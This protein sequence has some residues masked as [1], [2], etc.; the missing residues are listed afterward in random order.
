[1]APA[2]ALTA[3]SS[4]LHLIGS[5]VLSHTGMALF[6]LP[7][8]V[9]S[10]TLAAHGV[11][12]RSAGYAF[13]S[14]MML[15]LAVTLG[16]V[17][18]EAKPVRIIQANL[19]ASAIFSLLWLA[20]SRQLASREAEKQALP[21]LLLRSQIGFT[22]LAAL[23]LLAVADVRLLAD[24]WQPSQMAAAMGGAWGWVTVALPALAFARL[25]KWRLERLRIDWLGVGLLAIVSLVGCSV[26]LVAP[27]W[28]VYHALMIGIAASAWTMLALCWQREAIFNR[29]N[30]EGDDT[31]VL[32]ATCLGM[33]QVLVTLRGMEAPGDVWWTAGSFAVL[34]LLFTGLAVVTRHRGYVYL[35]GVF[36][37]LVVTRLAVWIAPQPG[38]FVSLILIN[39]I[40][41]CLAS[42]VW[43][44][45]DLT[46]MRQPGTSRIA[47]FHRIAAR[48]ALAVVAFTAA[49]HW[50]MN[51]G[52][53][54]FNVRLEWYA[55]GA[56][57][58]LLIG[59][60]WDDESDLSW[61]GLHLAGVMLVATA[62]ASAHLFSFP[63]LACTAAALSLYALA[64]VLLWR[65]RDA[66]TRMVERLRI[67]R[68]AGMSERVWSWLA[69][70][71]VLI[72]ALV[73]FCSLATV[74][75]SGSLKVRLLITTAAFA[76]PPAFALLA[77]GER[78]QRLIA[79]SI[80]LCLLDV[81]LWCWAWLQYP[82]QSTSLQL[83]NRL[84]IVML[85][86]EA[87]LI[88]Y[89]LVAVNQLSAESEWR[90]AWR[91]DLW[92][93]A[94]AGLASLAVVL[95]VEVSNYAILGSA[96]ISGP[97]ILAVLV[98]LIGLRLIGLAFA[99][100]PGEDPFGL[101]ERG[102]MRYVYA[103]E[104]FIVLTL[105]HVRVTMPWLFGGRFT[106]YWPLIVLAI[107]FAGV[108]LSEL[109]RRQGKL[110]LAE[111]LER[112]GALLPL[113]PVIGFW[114]V[115]SQVSYSMLLLL[116]GLF[117][118]WLSVIRHSFGFGLLAALA[119]N[120]GLW[121]FLHGEASYA[122]SEH[123]QLWMIP[124]ALSVLLATR[125][126][127][128]DGRDSLSAEQLSSIRYGALITIYVSSTADIFLNGVDDSP[129]LPIVLAVL[130]V[131]GVIAGI[132]LRI[133]SFLFLGTAF[134]LLSMLTMIWSAS[135][136]MHWAWLWWVTGIAL[137]VFI[138]YT[139]AMFE[140]K[141]EEMLR[142][143][144]QLKQWQ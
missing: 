50:L 126:T 141:R 104:G 19:T 69:K 52:V 30:P 96:L 144:G 86:A 63:L 6:L 3:F 54:P 56:L 137:G 60:L 84:V 87:V 29:V 32:W 43:L 40:T 61:R 109:F 51:L 42:L 57:V 73:A 143:V 2:L 131:C 1:A 74:F 16:L 94:V 113:L 71:N 136:N 103:V 24:A 132:M 123:P 114:A 101:D 81:L 76:L 75:G 91:D 67:P 115:G 128:K 37:N 65:R 46:V 38:D 68:R 41:L 106:T 13:A 8:C 122:F 110:I 4:F 59:C 83:I 107:A 48:I 133:R 23:A 28:T 77:R 105:M 34:C 111:P 12:K 100:L 62:F 17:F 134:L 66:L 39:V 36:C 70:S 116:A 112:T 33:A 97:V 18:A 21:S 88:A 80:R 49:I 78:R 102:R 58:A 90:T 31:S 95:S 47:P 125:I 118:G 135:V 10:L 139:F 15:N 138:L 85:I 130:S 124:A 45:L 117:Y 11:R 55:L 44:K 82:D 7:L 129:W 35:S 121:H 140:R 64:A 9:L 27:G 20:V 127:R 99:L 79:G 26:S 120:A 119:G 89:R 92:W 108:G 98:T 53:E 93:V 25:H 72:A 5:H 14:G 142:F 22:L